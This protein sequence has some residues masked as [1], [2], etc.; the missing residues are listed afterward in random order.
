M[1]CC[2]IEGDAHW[3]VNQLAE[4]FEQREEHKEIAKQLKQI[5]AKKKET[6]TIQ[7]KQ[8]RAK[9]L[10]DCRRVAGRATEEEE[11]ALTELRGKLQ[12]QEVSFKGKTNKQTMLKTEYSEALRG[13]HQVGRP[14]DAHVEDAKMTGPGH[15]SQP[16]P[17]PTPQEPRAA[18]SMRRPTPKPRLSVTGP[19]SAAA[20]A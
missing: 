19:T 3:F 9:C 2:G 6:E 20:P 10:G 18:E 4:L 14:E 5:V 16:V 8:D 7:T 12:Q 1:V 13:L 15:I 11:A 17:G